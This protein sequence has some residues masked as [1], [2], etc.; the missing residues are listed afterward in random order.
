MSVSGRWSKS[1]EKYR[2]R[3]VVY[4]LTDLRMQTLA[5]A[6][7][8]QTAENPE[9]GFQGRRCRLTLPILEELSLVAVAGPSTS[10]LVRATTDM[11]I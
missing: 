7:E 11:A 4:G 6:G 2:V 8:N 1:T 10:R 9:C 5:V 3:T